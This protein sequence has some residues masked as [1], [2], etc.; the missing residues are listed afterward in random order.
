M[1]RSPAPPAAPPAPPVLGRLVDAPAVAAD[2]PVTVAPPT[3][4]ACT[5]PQGSPSPLTM[6]TSTGS[7]PDARL[8][9]ALQSTRA[10][11]ASTTTLETLVELTSRVSAQGAAGA[12]PHVLYWRV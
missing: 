6:T 9:L 2:T 10:R 12:S 8:T 4:A 7:L 11:S 1:A 5:P 3:A